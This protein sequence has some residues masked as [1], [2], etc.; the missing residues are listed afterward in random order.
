[1]FENY[2]TTEGLGGGI[3]EALMRQTVAMY[4]QA[5]AAEAKR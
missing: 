5:K 3:R 4:D 1:L 2:L